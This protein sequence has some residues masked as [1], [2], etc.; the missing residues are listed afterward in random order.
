VSPVKYEMD[1]YIPE[2]A[3][4]HINRRE[5]FKPYV[6]RI[7][8]RQ[9]YIIANGMILTIVFMKIGKCVAYT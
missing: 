1:F 4:L 5:T 3:I 2:D 7:L 8:Y 9:G 6:M